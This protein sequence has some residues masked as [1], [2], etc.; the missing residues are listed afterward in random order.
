MDNSTL[1]YHLNST[2]PQ[3]NHSLNSSLKP[4][5]EKSASLNK[6]NSSAMGY[7]EDDSH[8]C[9]CFET[10]DDNMDV[11]VKTSKKKLVNGCLV[12]IVITAILI[13]YTFVGAVIFLAIEGEA[14]LYDILSVGQSGSH[15][16]RHRSSNY[17]NNMNST[18]SSNLAKLGEESRTRTVENIWDITVSLNILY[19]ENWTRL[20]AQEIT[21]FQEQLIQHLKE[22]MLAKQYLSSNENSSEQNIRPELHGKFEWNLAKSFLYSLT[23]LTTIGYGNIGPRTVMGKA[24]TMGY[25]ALGIP[26]MLIYLSSIGSLLSSCAR[27]V[28]TKSICCCLCSNCGYCCYDEK[29]MQE[30]E[31][32]MKK[33]R[34]RKEYEQQIQNI[35][36]HQEPFYLRSSS[37]TFTT[38]TS[39]NIHS[40]ICLD[41]DEL[42]LSGTRSSSIFMDSDC[43]SSNLSS[44]PCVRN[45]LA[46]SGS[47]I[48]PILFCFI[49]MIG[50]ICGGSVVL[51]H[52]EYSL[53]FLDSIFFCFMTLSTIG[54]GDSVPASSVFTSKSNENMIEGNVAVWFCSV[55]ILVGM[56]LTAMCFNVVHD[57]V[58]YRLNFHYKRSPTKQVYK[59]GSFSTK[60][61]SHINFLN[62]ES[63]ENNLMEYPLGS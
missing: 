44:T 46:S 4:N 23:V 12:N 55:Y 32:R 63:T 33:R 58:V 38:S 31:K 2:F 42:K 24:V 40:P 45:E 18:A 13:A 11:Y 47:C 60:L 25:A 49:L 20:A 3:H 5:D 36:L 51:C 35:H 22:E 61:G 16:N 39:N 6:L 14:G 37:S 56:A 34:E 27:G 43:L 9:F 15:Q 21:R 28:F 62:G 1:T 17:F 54:F 29:M 53:N 30:K 26:L 7:K 10:D 19:H 41:T 8:S 52:L 48:A 50:Y 57:E 59:E